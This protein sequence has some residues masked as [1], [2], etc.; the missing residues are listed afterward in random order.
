MSHKIFFDGKSSDCLNA[1]ITCDNPYDKPQRIVE[2]YTVPGHNGD[3]VIDTGRFGTVSRKYRL[4]LSRRSAMGVHDAL[5][6]VV[7]YFRL[8]GRLHELQD[9]YCSW[10]YRLARVASIN[11]AVVGSAGKTVDV[12]VELVCQPEIWL[13]GVT[14][15]MVSPAEGA[16]TA[17]NPTG[18]PAPA[19]IRVP[20]ASSDIV[21]TIEGGSGTATCTIKASALPITID[22]ADCTAEY[23]DGSGGALDHVSLSGDWVL[24]PGTSKITLAA[25]DAGIGAEILPRWWTI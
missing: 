13:L 23:S 19:T 17:I 20:S 5:Q 14:P 25:T 12:E 3:V 8:D 21:L 2:T 24:A 18:Y 16:A 9:D 6:A 4:R 7:D 10:G 22:T 11:P 1:I 15:I